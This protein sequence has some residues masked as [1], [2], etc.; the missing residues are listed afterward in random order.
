MSDSVWLTKARNF[1]LALVDRQPLI[2][3]F[4]AHHAVM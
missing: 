3:S 4:L 2:K 1:G